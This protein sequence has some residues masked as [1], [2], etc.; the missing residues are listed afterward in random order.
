[1]ESPVF[2]GSAAPYS[3]SARIK[4]GWLLGVEEIVAVREM[5]R[6][7]EAPVFTGSAAPSVPRMVH[8]SP[9]SPGSVRRVH[10][11]LSHCCRGSPYLPNRTSGA[12]RP[13]HNPWWSGHPCCYQISGPVRSVH[14]PWRSWHPM[15]VQYRI[16]G[17]VSSVPPRSMPRLRPAGPWCIVTLVSGQSISSLPDQR[18]RPSHP[19][20]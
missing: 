11:A 17:F 10:G 18:L 6:S 12:V 20:T 8:G 19:Y 9:G 4:T 2:I 13:V 15:F 16:S 1:M 7:T 3:F 14:G 5:P